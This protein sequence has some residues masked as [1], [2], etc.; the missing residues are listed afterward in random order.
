[1]RAVALSCREHRAAADVREAP[2]PVG[3]ESAPARPADRR[4]PSCRRRGPPRGCGPAAPGRRRRAREARRE[5]RRK[6]PRVDPVVVEVH[7]PARARERAQMPRVDLGAGRHPRAGVE[8]FALFPFGRGPDVLRVR[9]AAPG[10]PAQQRRIAGHRRGRMQEMRVQVDDVVRQLGRQ[11]EGLPDAANPVARGVAPE[12]APPRGDG[13]AV[14]GKAARMAPPA[15]DAHRLV[16]QV[17]RQ[18]DDRRPDLGVD[19]MRLA[20]RRM[21]QREEREAR[22]RAARAR[23]SPAR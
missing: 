13:G 1:M 10:E 3:A 22:P 18:V 19:R 23:G 20:I 16:V 17:L 7:G 6:P 14:S 11:H 21:P 12:V 5:R 4:S 2:V 8:L 15:E 9:G